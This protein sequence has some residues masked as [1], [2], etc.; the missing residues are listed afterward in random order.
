MATKKEQRTLETASN[1]AARFIELKKQ[2]DELT[3]EMTLH[4]KI[5][6]DFARSVDAVSME[7]NGLKIERRTTLKCTIDKSLALPHWLWEMRENGYLSLLDIGVDV[8]QVPEAGQDEILTR[9]LSEV[10]YTEKETT[11]Y[12]VRI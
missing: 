6:T 8:K 11:T 4:K 2:V 1:S 3:K 10:G 9:L 12:A 7:L 5:C